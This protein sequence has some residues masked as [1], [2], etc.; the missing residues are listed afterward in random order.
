[1][2]R[3]RDVSFGRNNRLFAEDAPV[4][5]WYRFVLSFPPHLVREYLLDHIKLRSGGTVLDPFCGTGTTVVE[6]KKLG[7]SGFGLES[8]PMACF[9]TATK[10]NWSLDPDKLEK[11]GNHL[12]DW[13]IEYLNK[14]GTPEIANESADTLRRTGQ[15]S[16]VSSTSPSALMDAGMRAA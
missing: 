5:E 1:M 16:I 15:K 14:I 13:C 12:A 11:R 9:A 2:Q 3:A 7:F 8:S 10:V 6:A 4:H